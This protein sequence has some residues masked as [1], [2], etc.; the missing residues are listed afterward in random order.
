MTT[1]GTM[2]A[3]EDGRGVVRVEDVYDTGIDDL[4]QACTVPERL[5]RWIGRVD[6]NLSEGSTVQAVFTSTWTGAVKIETCDAPHHLLLTMEPGTD[7]QTQV[8]AWLTTEDTRTRLVV[9]E[10]GL[11]T[12]KLHFY[13]SGWQV[14]LEDLG[15]SLDAGGSV[16]LEGWSSEAPAPAWHERWTEL[17]PLYRDAEVLLPS[18][19]P[20]EAS[21]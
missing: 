19:S 13:G 2:H 3:L 9:E 1:T 18:S 6:G 15:R 10:R 16:H 11:P 5:A 14:H 20:S 4:W 21:G 12:D 8:E 7:D 17:T